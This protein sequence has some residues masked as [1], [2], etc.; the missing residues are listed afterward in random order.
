M[1]LNSLQYKDPRDGGSEILTNYGCQT[2]CVCPL[3]KLP[4][5]HGDVNTTVIQ[6][7]HYP[8]C[9]DV[10]LQLDVKI[11]AQAESLR[12]LNYCWTK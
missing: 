9:S 5:K 3:D 11:S 7:F 10:L 8:D 6:K 4:L 1:E 12:T 2:F